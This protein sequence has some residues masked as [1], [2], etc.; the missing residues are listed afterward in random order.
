MF[1]SNFDFNKQQSNVFRM[2]EQVNSY[3]LK[4]CPSKH[5]VG[6][7]SVHVLVDVKFCITKYVL[8]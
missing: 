3:K 1:F 5:L 7:N 6:F 8:G 2:L 4:I